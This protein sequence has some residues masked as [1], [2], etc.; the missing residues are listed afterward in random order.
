MI[1]KIISGGC[2]IYPKGSYQQIEN[3]ET[4]KLIGR[5]DIIPISY[6]IE[7][8]ADHN[9]KNCPECQ[10]RFDWDHV[11][12]G[13]NCLRCWE[14]IHVTGDRDAYHEAIKQMV[15]NEMLNLITAPVIKPVYG[16]EAGEVLRNSIIKLQQAK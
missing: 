9:Y 4:R 10:N 11:F 1:V 14:R 3:I 6:D 16:P 15:I 7:L 12:I 5:L 2:D 8:A 13:E